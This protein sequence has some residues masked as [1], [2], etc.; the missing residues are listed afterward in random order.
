MKTMMKMVVAVSMMLALAG[1]Q[2]TS[3]RETVDGVVSYSSNND[4]PR[5]A[6]SHTARV[7]YWNA[8]TRT[9]KEALRAATAYKDIFKEEVRYA[10]G[11]SG[12]HAGQGGFVAGI[13]YG[14]DV[15]VKAFMALPKSTRARIAKQMADIEDAAAE[16]ILH[17][18]KARK[19]IVS[20]ALWWLH[21]AEQ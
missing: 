3:Y 9:M 12:L 18:P 19:Q 1:C 10:E 21:L 5:A 11:V 17:N 13:K 20:Y 7:D 2:S 6:L 8:R 4:D 15:L 16:S 14:D